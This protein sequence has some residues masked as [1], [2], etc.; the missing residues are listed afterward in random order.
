MC[1]LAATVKVQFPYD[2]TLPD[3]LSM[4]PGDLIVQEEEQKD[5]EEW[6]KG[7]L[8]G[9]SG[10]FYQPF[11]CEPVMSAQS[12]HPSLRCY[13]Q[14][15]EAAFLN[16]DYV[17]LEKPEG[18]LECTVCQQLAYKPHQIPCCGGQT[19]CKTCAE[20]WKKRSNNCPLC[21][22]S[23][24]ETLPDVRGE[25]FVNNLQTYC[26]NY[27]HGCDWRGD[28]K[29]VKEHVT[30]VCEWFVMDCT[31]GMSMPRGRFDTHK[32]NECTNRVVHCPCC[33]EV[34]T[35]SKIVL[36]HYHSCPNWPVRCPNQCQGGRATLTRGTVKDHCN[37]ECPEQVF[38]CKYASMGCNTK[39]K[40]REI[41]SHMQT[42][43][44]NH[45]DQLMAEY[46]SVVPGLV[47]ENEALKQRVQQ[48]EQRLN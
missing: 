41:L 19:I 24:F 48:L 20:E 28:L 6:V 23:P 7:T 3:E 30:A 47:K 22:R 4:R 36:E 1:L 32:Q 8:K 17:L 39:G 42:D 29:S 34:D 14:G 16:K 5:D 11:T 44:A 13:P 15:H 21:R 35:Y 27:A 37:S 45:L 33:G 43:M 18:W 26:P 25:R 46:T 9:K 40:R 2:T 12:T 38:A 31:C 10:L